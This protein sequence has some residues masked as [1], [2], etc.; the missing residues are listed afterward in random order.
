MFDRRRTVRLWL[1]S[2]LIDI[3][4]ACGVLCLLF[5]RDSHDRWKKEDNIRRMIS[6]ILRHKTNSRIWNTLNDFE[7]VYVAT[8]SS[9][10]G[11]DSNLK[12]A[13][14][15]DQSWILT[16]VSS[17][18][19]LQVSWVL[20]VLEIVMRD[21]RYSWLENSRVKTM[22]EEFCYLSYW[23]TNKHKVVQ[24]T[25]RSYFDDRAR[26]GFA[27][28]ARLRILYKDS[29][30]I[31]IPDWIKAFKSFKL[32]ILFEMIRSDSNCFLLISSFPSYRYI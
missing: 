4:T 17:L 27:S 13:E 28:W 15:F 26:S 29:K 16:E 5:Y 30:P 12:T 24:R 31:N 9:H 8:N 6:D 2:G 14:S 11:P 10:F 7:S 22:F 20:I 23:N 1:N 32:R 19:T 25:R 21:I 3:H 18:W